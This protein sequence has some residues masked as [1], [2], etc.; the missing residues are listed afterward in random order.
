MFQ[1]IDTQKKNELA[2]MQCLFKLKQNF[3]SQ[4]R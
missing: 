1:Y 3:W 4:G 2:K